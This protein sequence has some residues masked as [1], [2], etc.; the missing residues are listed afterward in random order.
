MYRQN[1]CGCMFSQVEAAEHRERARAERKLLRAKR[2]IA[3]SARTAFD[4]AGL[5]GDVHDDIWEEEC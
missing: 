5:M 4:N 3:R 1:F 2:R